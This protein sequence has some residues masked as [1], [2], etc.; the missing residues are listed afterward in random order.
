MAKKRRRRSER[1]DALNPRRGAAGVRIE[2]EKYEAVRTA[3]VQAVPRDAVGIAFAR[4]AAAVAAR[5]PRTL[6]KDASIRWYTTTV[7]LDLEARGVLER[8][9]GLRP[10]HVRRVSAARSSGR[11]AKRRASRRAP[12]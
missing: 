7:K 4:L 1:I 8:T 11:K 9:P 5:V 6:F 12:A 3:I 10:Q 2:R